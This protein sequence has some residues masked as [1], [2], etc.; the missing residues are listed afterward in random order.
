MRGS[1]RGSVVGADSGYPIAGAMISG[2]RAGLSPPGSP[3]R[4]AI[5]GRSDRSGAFGFD[6][7]IE[8]EWVFTTQG[9]RGEVL[10]TA[11]VRVLDNAFSDV[12]I[13]VR[14]VWGDSP[15]ERTDS[16]QNVVAP[17]PRTPLKSLPGSVRGVVVRDFDTG[18]PVP[19]ARI[20]V[21]SGEGREPDVHPVTDADG[22]FALDGLPEGEWLLRALGPG[23]ET[24]RATVH[25]F[26]NALSDVTIEIAGGAPRT[27]RRGGGTRSSSR[28]E[29]GMRGSL[30]GRVIRG[31]DGSPIPDATITVMTGPGPAPDIAP[32]SDDSGVFRLDGLPAGQ[33]TLRA[34]ASD[35][36]R[37]EA[38]VSVTAGAVADVIIY[39]PTGTE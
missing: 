21:V 37:G 39:V 35:G 23:G 32:V 5:S 34:I 12:T 16:D 36:S 6:G 8:G 10:G 19:G 31:D 24:G 11:T 38:K 13:A 28:S 22:A 30:Q 9:S 1:V 15:I 20:S 4:T 2:S 25:V 18:Q 17:R 33:W 29:R 14:G 27:P 7:L 26:E 3:P